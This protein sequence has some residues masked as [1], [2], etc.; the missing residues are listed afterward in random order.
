MSRAKVFPA[1]A[2]SILTKTGGYLSAF[3]HTLQPYKGCEFS[4]AY[5]YVR[6]LPVQRMSPERRPWSNWIAPKTNAV[7]LLADEARR[8]RLEHARIFFSSATDPYTPIERRLKLTRGCLEVMREYPPAA[9]VLQTRSPLVLRDLQLLRA[10]PRMVVNITV[11]TDDENIRRALEPDSPAIHK[12]IEALAALK[13]AGIRTQA[14][15]SPLLPC[16]AERL[17]DMLDPVID[18]VIVD[19]FFEGDGAGGRRSRQAIETLTELGYAA[20]TQ[21]GYADQTLRCLRE[22]LGAARVVYS[23]T[24]FNDIDWVQADV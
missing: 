1:E 21:P 18:R 12:R 17:A 10:I 20:W 15:L 23:Q 13:S 8:G 7:A 4:C 5:C 16:N 24:G 9:L 14:T 6:A 2:K 3:T 19:D 22:K 11:T